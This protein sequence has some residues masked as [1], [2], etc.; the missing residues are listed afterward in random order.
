M[1]KKMTETTE[2]A[3]LPEGAAPAAVAAVK[4]APGKSPAGPVIYC[5]PEIRGVL[6]PF[7]V[8]TGK[9]PGPVEAA[10]KDPNVGRLLVPLA[11]FQRVRKALEV[12]GSPERG[13]YAAAE[14]KKI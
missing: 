5:G 11:Q 14:G 13:W 3:A 8:Y 2:A 7:A 1:S 10:A 4:A 9:L 6:R 12:Q